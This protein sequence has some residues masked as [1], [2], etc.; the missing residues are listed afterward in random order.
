M[1]KLK[2]K[3]FVIK[4]NQPFDIK[5]LRVNLDIEELRLGKYILGRELK[6]VLLRAMVLNFDSE[7]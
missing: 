6:D 2:I 1:A 5:L 7:V 4:M 3:Y